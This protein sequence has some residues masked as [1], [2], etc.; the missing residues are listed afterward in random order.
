MS[1]GNPFDKS[2]TLNKMFLNPKELLITGGV[3]LGYRFFKEDVGGMFKAPEMP[4]VEPAP[5][6]LMD[7]S[8]A[9][10]NAAKLE[11]ERLRKRKGMKSTIMTE[12]SKL[13]APVQT[14]KAEMLG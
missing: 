4:A 12:D 2:N 1:I 3:P 8:E 11:A 6:P 10:K 13:M 5:A 7:N 9:L 14:Q